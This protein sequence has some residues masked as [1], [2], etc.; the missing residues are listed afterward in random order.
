MDT[1]EAFMFSDKPPTVSFHR[2]I[3]ASLEERCAVAEFMAYARKNNTRILI[4]DWNLGRGL[5][6]KEKIGLRVYISR[7]LGIFRTNFLVD[8]VE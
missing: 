3:K 6:I 4:R 2:G 5:H 8:Y 1:T 7:E